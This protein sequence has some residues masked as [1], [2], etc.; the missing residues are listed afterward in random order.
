MLRK[1]WN[2]EVIKLLTR[3]RLVSFETAVEFATY[4]DDEFAQKLTP[5]AA[6][7]QELAYWEDGD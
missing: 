1:D 4:A 2:N 7:D 3:S 5:Q 6:V